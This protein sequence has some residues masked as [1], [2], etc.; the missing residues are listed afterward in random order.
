MRDWEALNHQGSCILVINLSEMMR[1]IR[2][3]GDDRPDAL[4]RSQGCNQFDLKRAQKSQLNV[5]FTHQT[6]RTDSSNSKWVP[7]DTSVYS[8]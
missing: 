5:A 8:P 6:T 3:S 1:G 7:E 2:I 4:A